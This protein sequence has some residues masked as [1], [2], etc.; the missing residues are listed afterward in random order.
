[1]G[2]S[3]N[4]VHR[5]ERK[6]KDGKCIYRR[7]ESR[8]LDSKGICND[9]LEGKAVEIQARKGK[10]PR[11]ALAG[12][13]YKRGSRS[14]EVEWNGETILD[15]HETNGSVLDVY[16]ESD[17]RAFGALYERLASQARA[18][19]KPKTDEAK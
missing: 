2:V 14:I 3:S 8:P 9:L 7:I 11:V 17:A 16:R 6:Y 5:I 15:L 19:F 12:S 18:L 13:S 4:Q 10:G 1:M